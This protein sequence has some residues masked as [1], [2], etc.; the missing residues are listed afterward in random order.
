V[1]EEGVAIEG[2]I[3]EAVKRGMVTEENRENW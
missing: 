2:G 1:D 3:M